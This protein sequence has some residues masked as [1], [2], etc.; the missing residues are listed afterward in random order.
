MKHI[1]LIVFLLVFAN[2]SSAQTVSRKVLST[3]GGSYQDSNFSATYTVG[4]TII[5][6]LSAGG[7]TA[8]QGFQ[9]PSCQTDSSSFADS[10]ISSYVWNGI[11]YTTSGNYQHIYINSLGCD[12]I[13]TLNLTIYFT[14]VSM[15]LQ[16]VIQISPTVFE[17]DVMLQN[18][19]N[20]ALALKG[21]SCGL[22]HASG[23]RNGGTLTHTFLSRDAALSTIP[24]VV[25]GYTAS[26]NHLRLFTSDAS[27]GNEVNLLPGTPIR[28]ATMRVSN[29]VPFPKRF[30]A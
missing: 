14:T 28:I 2:C 7:I 23:M 22:N 16:N 20:T 19:G 4:E 25:P 17:Y 15:T 3:I 24:N 6:T 21:Y 5:T 11:T 10:G 27:A 1:P 12:S 30:L 29:S 18:T 9:Q 13:V 8:A 26:T